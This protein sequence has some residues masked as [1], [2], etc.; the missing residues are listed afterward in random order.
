MVI[1]SVGAA[2]TIDCHSLNGS[3]TWYKNAVKVLYSSNP[4]L[5][6]VANG[7]LLVR[8]ASEVDSGLYQVFARTSESEISSPPILLHVVRK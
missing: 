6:V 7:S 5:S 1:C 8:N 3:V 2:V 4:T